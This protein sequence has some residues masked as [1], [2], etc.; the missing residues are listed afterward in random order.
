MRR[1]ANRARHRFAHRV[2]PSDTV[3]A[4]HGVAVA[5]AV[6]MLARGPKRAGPFTP[7][8][9]EQRNHVARQPP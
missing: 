1:A 3:T 6:V 9:N 2:D 7:V 5:A 4:R 8:P